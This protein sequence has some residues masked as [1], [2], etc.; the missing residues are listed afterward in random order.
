MLEGGFNRKN[1]LTAVTLAAGVSMLLTGNV[2]SLWVLAVMR[3]FHAA[4]NSMIN[5]LL[6]SLVAD[7]YPKN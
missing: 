7:Y 3:V 4:F 5:P 1:F 6:Y 2:S